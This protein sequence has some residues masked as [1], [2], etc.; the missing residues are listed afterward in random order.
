MH[1]SFPRGLGESE[2]RKKGSELE[3]HP[4]R[5]TKMEQPAEKLPDRAYPP[6]CLHLPWM[7]GSHLLGLSL[8]FSPGC[9]FRGGIPSFPPGLDHP[10]ARHR[11]S[12]DAA[13]SSPQGSEVRG[14][15]SPR[16]GSP[17]SSSRR[18]PRPQ[19]WGDQPQSTQRARP[20]RSRAA[21]WKRAFP[22]RKS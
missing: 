5:K 17:S 2:N 3:K 22:G 1:P 4:E 13:I 14:S 8:H 10:L 9:C 15:L 11:F 7:T 19:S 20:E 21:A 18:Q 12:P 6:C 16:W